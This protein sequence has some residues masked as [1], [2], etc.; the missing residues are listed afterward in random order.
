MELFE[1]PE[2]IK[3]LALAGAFVVGVLVCVYVAVKETVELN[4]RRRAKKII[5]Q[6]DV[7]REVR[8]KKAAQRRAQEQ[9]NTESFA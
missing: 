5:Y 2:V 8:R 3:L 6:Q 4:R 1:D 9:A 7:Q